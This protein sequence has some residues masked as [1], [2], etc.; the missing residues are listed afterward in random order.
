MELGCVGALAAIWLRSYHAPMPNLRGWKVLLLGAIV[1]A[2]CS[3][4]GP[5]DD[6]SGGAGNATPGTGTAGWPGTGLLTDDLVSDFEGETAT[7]ARLGGRNGAWYAYNDGSTGCVQVPAPG[8]TFSP[9]LAPVAAP[10]PSGGKALK[11]EWK[12]CNIFGAGIGANLCVPL[13]AGDQVYAGPLIGCDLRMFTGLTLWARAAPGTAYRIRVKVP[14]LAELKISDGGL[15]DETVVGL[16]KC[17]DSWG[18]WIALPADGSWKQIQ[19]SFSSPNFHQEGWGAIFPWDPTQVAG[20]Q[21]QSTD[22]G[23]RYE[24]WIDDVYLVRESGLA[25]TAAG[26]IR[27]AGAWY[28]Y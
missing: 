5:Y 13:T 7:V 6:G 21:I 22:I 14:M 20:I 15:C 2:G 18:Q 4:T 12:A 8:T 24:L 28:S 11:A 10:G 23:E 9:E 27:N 16:N 19:L 3:Q 17:G 26:V 1:A 25:G